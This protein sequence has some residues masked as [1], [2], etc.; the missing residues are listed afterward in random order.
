MASVRTEGLSKVAGLEDFRG[1]L[2][3][4]CV[5]LPILHIADGS[6]LI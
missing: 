2:D 3:G 1:H 4:G 5:A 6:K